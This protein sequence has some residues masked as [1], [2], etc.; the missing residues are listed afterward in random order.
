M[1]PKYFL[2]CLLG[3]ALI[4]CDSDSNRSKLETRNNP[5]KKICHEFTDD[6]QGKCTAKLRFLSSNYVIKK[7]HVYWMTKTEHEEKPC[8][9]GMPF[10]FHNLLSWRCFTSEENQIDHIEMRRLRSVTPYSAG[11][12]ALEGSAP[13]LATWQQEKMKIYAKNEKSVFFK[14][15]EIVGADPNNFEVAFPF[16][17]DEFWRDIDVSTS[18]KPLFSR[19]KPIGNIELNQFRAFTPVRCPKNGLS[20]VED[21]ENNQNDG[22]RHGIVGWIGDDILVIHANGIDRFPGMASP[23]VFMFKTRYKIYLHAKKNFYE[24]SHVRD[25]LLKMDTEFYERYNF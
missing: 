2:I 9:F 18:G 6:S 4:G 21:I 20:C 10:F 15:I 3:T 17:D 7:G 12:K 1:K 22:S 16:P 25:K 24:L 11:F 14:G 23:D 5:G 19:W 13:L 8:G